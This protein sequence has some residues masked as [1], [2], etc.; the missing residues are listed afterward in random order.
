MR[1]FDELNGVPD[2]KEVDEIDELI[3]SVKKVYSFGLDDKLPLEYNL[4][5]DP[6]QTYPFYSELEYCNYN[7]KQAID[8]VGFENL[9]YSLEEIILQGV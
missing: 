9:K 3:K 7:I 1:Y 5:L 8:V 2:D 4:M 6:Y